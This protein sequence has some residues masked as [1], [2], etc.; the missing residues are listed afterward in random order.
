M[1][2][3]DDPD[4]EAAAFAARVAE[5]ADRGEPV[6]LQCACGPNPRP[7][8]IN[9][10]IRMHGPRVKALAKEHP[11]AIFIFPFVDRPWDLPDSC[12]DFISNEDFI[13]HL[14][15][16][17]QVLFLAETLRVLKPDCW[18]RINTPCLLHSMKVHSTFAQGFRGVYQ[19]EWQRWGH[20]AVLTRHGLEELAAMVGY[21]AV[22]FN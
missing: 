4:A 5:L 7:D 17:Q 13:E 1:R 8:F 10:D 20:Q 21:R 19:S 18:H 16:R 6:K 3:T 9:L 11:D 12:I 15:Q 22:V 14:T 2:S